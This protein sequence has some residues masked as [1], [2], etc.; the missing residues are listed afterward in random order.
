MKKPEPRDF[1]LTEEE[2]NRW[3]SGGDNPYMLPGFTVAL[4]ISVLMGMLVV[5]RS[6]DVG[7]GF[8]LGIMVFVVLS[9]LVAWAFDDTN[10]LRP[11]VSRAIKYR[12][13]LARYQQTQEQH[14]TT[15]KGEEFELEVGKV[16][17]RLGY[18]VRYTPVTADEGIDLFLYKGGRTYIVQ[19][20]AHRQPVS[21]A[22]IRELYGTMMASK[23]E[24]AIPVSASGFTKGVRS[25]AIGKPIK[26]VSTSDLIKMSE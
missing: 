4:F 8:G 25:F 9:A 10:K 11:L 21:P 12:E 26:L 1:D 2:Y 5:S 16:Y 13:A 3:A 20:K 19:C 7:T 17:G 15:L 18:K 22:V 23:A 24:G 6:S 14:W